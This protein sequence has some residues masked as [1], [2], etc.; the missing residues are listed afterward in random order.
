M[1]VTVQGNTIS[2]EEF[3]AG[4]WTPVL[5][6]A[7]ASRAVC[8]QKP[9]SQPNATSKV[10]KPN[11]GNIACVERAKTGRGKMPAHLPLATKETRI[12]VQ[13]SKQLPTLPPNAIRVVV[14]PRG[15]LRLRDVPRPRLMKAMQAALQIN[16]PDD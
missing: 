9:L 12:I 1:E 5:Y 2:A 8:S 15:Q 3:Q 6:N 11:T 4:N 16:L 13:L 10:A 14:R 7:Y